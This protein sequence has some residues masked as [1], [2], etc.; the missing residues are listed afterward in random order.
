MTLQ[1]FEQISDLKSEINL[2]ECRMGKMQK[3][4]D[5]VG[6][7]GLNPNRASAFT[8]RGYAVKDEKRLEKLKVEH[9]IKKAELKAQEDKAEKFIALVPD[10]TVRVLLKARFLEGWP[11]EIAAR[12][13]YK[14]MT[15]DA[16]RKRVT[17]YFEEK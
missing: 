16:A 4:G 10:A 12:I 15:A 1:E 14:Q 17:R 2:L 6:D 7:Y 9:R 13:I 8:I 11:W 5:F 3:K